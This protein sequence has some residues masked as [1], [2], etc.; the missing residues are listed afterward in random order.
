MNRKAMVTLVLLALSFGLIQ[1]APKIFV[2]DAQPPWLTIEIPKRLEYSN[3]W[4][5]CFNT[6]A[7]KYDIEVSE[8]ESGYIKTA[9]TY[10]VGGRP[11]DYYRFK[12]YVNIKYSNNV[13]E[14]KSEAQ[15]R[16]GP[17]D[18]GPWRIGYDTGILDEGCADIQGQ[19]GSAIK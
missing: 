4:D 12:I 10:I 3:V 16:D 19:L 5:I 9:W 11:V 18:I 7:K 15:Y 13:I 1:C 8:K 6:L 14:V 2:Q 17:P